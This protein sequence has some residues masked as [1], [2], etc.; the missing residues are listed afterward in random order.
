MDGIQLDCVIVG[1]FLIQEKANM[2]SILLYKQSVVRLETK[3]CASL[4]M[5]SYFQ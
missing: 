2:T 1:S 4:F 5:Y 3:E